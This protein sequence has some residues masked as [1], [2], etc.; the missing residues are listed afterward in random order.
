MKA[1][2]LKEPMKKKLGQRE[3]RRIHQQKDQVKVARVQ[4]VQMKRRMMN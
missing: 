3:S 2:Y 4:P 1:K